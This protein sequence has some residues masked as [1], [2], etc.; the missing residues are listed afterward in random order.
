MEYVWYSANTNEIMVLD[1]W[2]SE[3][4]IDVYFTM[5]LEAVLTGDQY[6]GPVCIG[7]L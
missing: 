3:T 7:G 5:A 1:R 2:S 6:V 4:L